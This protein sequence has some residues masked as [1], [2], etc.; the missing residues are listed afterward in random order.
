MKWGETEVFMKYSPER[1]EAI[2]RKLLPQNNRP[3]AEVAE[4]EGISD[5]TLYNWRNEA[6]KNEQLLPD[7]RSDPEDWSSRDKFNAVL[8]TANDRDERLEKR[9]RDAVNYANHSIS[10]RGH[11]AAQSLK[12]FLIVLFDPPGDDNR[13]RFH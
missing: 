10:R 9:S 8:E 13:Q 2:L 7:H 11:L 12:C 4:E 3:V 1:R 6:R 5:A